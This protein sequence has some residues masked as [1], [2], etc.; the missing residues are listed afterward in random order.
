MTCIR[1]TGAEWWGEPA[2]GTAP[3]VP[4]LHSF[5]AV[6]LSAVPVLVSTFRV[7][8][9]SRGVLFVHLLITPCYHLNYLILLWI[10]VEFTVSWRECLAMSAKR[11][12]VVLTISQ[13]LE[14]CNKFEN[15]TPVKT[16]CADYDVGN[17]TVRD[18]LKQK[19]KLTSYASDSD[20]FYVKKRKSMKRP[21]YEELEKALTKWISQQ[22]YHDGAT[23]TGPVIASK[24][25]YFHDLLGMKGSFCASSGWLTGFKNRHGIKEKSVEEKYRDRTAEEFR[26]SFENLIALEELTSNQIYYVAESGLLWRRFPSSLDQD[27]NN[28]ARLTL[29]TGNNASGDHKL[30]LTIISQSE[31]S[32]SATHNAVNWYHNRRGSMTHKI[33][34]CWFHN[35]FVP[36]VCEYLLSKG[37]PP[38]AVLLLEDSPAHSVGNILKS[39]DGN[40]SALFMPRPL[41][42]SDSLS[43]CTDSVAAFTKK[44]YRSNLLERIIREGQDFDEFWKNYS[45]LDCVNDI[46]AVW[47]SCNVSTIYQPWTEILPCMK[48]VKFDWTV[49]HNGYA[50]T[51]ADLAKSMAGKARLDEEAIVKWFVCDLTDPGFECLS[52]GDIVDFAKEV[53]T[54]DAEEDVMG[55]KSVSQ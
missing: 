27:H 5:I 22:R 17:S 52:D 3:N 37:L 42:V 43:R 25:K 40:I 53:D 28:K 7:Y 55:G 51:V 24:A 54:E 35:H 4:T 16:I 2:L 23:V 39:E 32:M 34:N 20:N 14:L 48:D 33:I 36:E 47:K 19:D 49:Q 6:G 1:P 45:V 12:R 50:R 15:G 10:S 11:K 21:V 26:D 44:M 41:G 13:K 29:M 46:H 38:K 9:T 30:K 8:C 18:I 31:S